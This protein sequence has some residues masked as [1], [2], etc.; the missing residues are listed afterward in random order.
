MN[1]L[2]ISVLLVV[3]CLLCACSGLRHLPPDKFLG[4]A[5]AA[6]VINTMDNTEYIGAA[7]GNAYLGHYITGLPFK[8]RVH[9]VYWT[10]IADLPPDIQ[11]Q[12][13]SGKNPWANQWRRATNNEVLIPPGR[14]DS[15]NTNLGR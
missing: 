3:A 8:I 1:K 5:K 13:N 4:H 6:G 11:A 12:L 7:Y 2:K 14:R 15:A 9:R 10:R